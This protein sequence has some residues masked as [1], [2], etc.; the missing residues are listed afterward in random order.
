[1]ADQDISINYKTTC[2]EYNKLLIEFYK[3]PSNDI[4]KIVDISNVLHKETYVH[5]FPEF[6]GNDNLPNIN[7]VLYIP[8]LKVNNE[9]QI[10]IIS[11]NPEGHDKRNYSKFNYSIIENYESIEI[12]ITQLKNSF[13]TIQ[14]GMHIEPEIEKKLTENLINPFKSYYADVQYKFNKLGIENKTL[15]FS[16]YRDGIIQD[17]PFENLRTADNIP[18]G[19]KLAINYI[20]K[21]EFLDSN[22]EFNRP[23]LILSEIN[24]WSNEYLDT[25]E[26][27]KRVNIVLS[28]R[29]VEV[30]SLTRDNANIA[31]LKEILKTKNPSILHFATH[32]MYNEK[33]PYDSVGIMLSNTGLLSFRDI[34]SL[35]LTNVNLAVLS[36]CQSSVT[37]ENENKSING[38]AHAF[39]LAGAKMVLGNK[40]KVGN[41]QTV[42]FMQ[43]FYEYLTYNTATEALRLTREYYYTTKFEDFMFIYQNISNEIK[44]KIFKKFIG[45]WILWT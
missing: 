14:Q 26:E 17:I 31:S 24:N 37:V 34:S 15:D 27:L 38:I 32:G 40:E 5:Y 10:L 45:D 3:K 18:L 36:L 25:S 29:N 23:T 7:T 8:L 4:N 28:N 2:N 19:V 21:N 44:L 6:T 41:A 35:H 39:L 12:Y 9:R 22:I 20:A 33:L 11:F 30:I 43:K 13:T 16:I 1:M 42:I